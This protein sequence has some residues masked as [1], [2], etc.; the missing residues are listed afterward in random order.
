MPSREFLQDK[1][2]YWMAEERKLLITDPDFRHK[3]KIVRDA[4]EAYREEL[5]RKEPD[6]QTTLKAIIR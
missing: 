5:N 2:R 6:T 3:S 1:I 4:L